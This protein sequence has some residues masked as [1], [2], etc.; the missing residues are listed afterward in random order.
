MDLLQLRGDLEHFRF[1]LKLQDPVL[2]SRR[3]RV[4]KK[5]GHGSYGKV[6]LAWDERR[7]WAVSS[8]VLHSSSKLYCTKVLYNCT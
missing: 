8:A 3:Y 6:Y 2:A 5:L 4:V 7:M 1:P